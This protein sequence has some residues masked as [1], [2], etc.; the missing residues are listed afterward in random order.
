MY[1]GIENVIA[2]QNFVNP[3]LLPD[4]FDYSEEY[5][6]LTVKLPQSIVFLFKNEDDKDSDFV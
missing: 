6:D 2:L 4:I 3:L 5:E 1:D